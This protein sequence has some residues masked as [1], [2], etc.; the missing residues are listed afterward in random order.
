MVNIAMHQSGDDDDDVEDG[1]KPPRIEIRLTVPTSGRA[2]GLITFEIQQQLEATG[3]LFKNDGLLPLIPSAQASGFVWGEG[4]RA[5]DR[6]P[7]IRI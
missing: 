4:G 6:R 2:L 1:S 5:S 7:M 3:A